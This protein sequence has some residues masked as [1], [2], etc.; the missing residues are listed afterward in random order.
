MDNLYWTRQHATIIDRIRAEQLEK[1]EEPFC[2]Y[3]PPNGYISGELNE[4]YN[5]TWV[6]DLERAC[7]SD[8]RSRIYRK[9]WESARESR[10]AGDDEGKQL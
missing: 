6:A 10:L 8:A 2:A 1:V 4:V 5:T 9:E 7:G 3:L